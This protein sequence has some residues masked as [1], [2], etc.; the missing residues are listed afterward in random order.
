LHSALT[1]WEEVSLAER[2]ALVRS[3]LK[4][5]VQVWMMRLGK[6]KLL[7]VYGRIKFQ[8][9]ARPVHAKVAG[10]MDST[11]TARNFIVQIEIN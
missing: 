4:K 11:S 9:P 6:L 7:M 8:S 2:R 10:I 3:H 1:L 5:K